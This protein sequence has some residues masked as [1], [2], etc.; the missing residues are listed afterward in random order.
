MHAAL[1]LIHVA[2]AMVWAGGALFVALF[3]TPA[4]RSAGDGAGPFM[5]A[6]SRG[7]LADVMTGVSVLTVGSGVWLW[8]RAFG[9]APPGDVRGFAVGV[10]AIAGIVA[11]L[12][13]LFRQRPTVKAIQALVAEMSSGDGPPS[14][15]QL[16]RM[17]VLRSRMMTTGNLLA[18]AAGIAVVGM[19][20]AG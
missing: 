4:A 15:D 16:G 8:V 11:M 12:I 3:V 20:L 17:S 2:S 1:N 7:P 18:V 10:G 19:G 5:G 13:A 9:G 6:L 14:A